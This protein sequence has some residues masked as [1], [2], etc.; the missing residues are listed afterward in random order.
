MNKAMENEKRL[1]PQETALIVKT[2]PRNKK[3]T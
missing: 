3:K 1:N 2:S